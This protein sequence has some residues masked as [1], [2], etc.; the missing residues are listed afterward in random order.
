MELIS[1]I[2]TLQNI[3]RD[4][5]ESYLTWNKEGIRE[6]VTTN[7]DKILKCRTGE[8]GFHAYRCPTCKEVK[9]VPHS[10]KSRFCSS[11]G[12]IATDNWI[13]ERLSDILPV[14]YHHLVFTIPWQLRIICISNR[15]T[16]FDLLFSALNKSIQS[17]TKEYGNYIAG[18]YIVLHTFGSDIKFNPHFHVLI[19]AGGLRLDKKKWKT[20]PKNFLM[21]ESGLKKRWRFNVV[22]AIIKANNKNNLIMPILNKTNT[23]LNIRGVVSAISKLNWYVF[24]GTRLSE[25]DF[26]I[27][28][29]GRYTKRPV[30][31]ETRII[32]VTERWVIFRYKDYACEGKSEVKKTGLFIFIKYLTQHIPDKNFRQV[33]GYG[34]FCNRNKSDAIEIVLKLLKKKKKLKV[35]KKAWRENLAKLLG[36][37]PLTCD[38]CGIE[39]EFWFARYGPDEQSLV[40]FGLKKQDR[41]PVKQFALKSA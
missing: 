2:V 4:Y 35:N 33:R 30:I 24:I 16:M 19:T 27:K 7:V 26:S 39:M 18:F 25:A 32:N 9:L 34:L 21:P 14:E 23:I 41:I 11:C 17:W 5:W 40:K 10:C 15:K 38:N 28:Y 13:S 6:A 31:S 37:D 12:K 29:I 1:G 3:F 8:L 20:A 22:E 36:N